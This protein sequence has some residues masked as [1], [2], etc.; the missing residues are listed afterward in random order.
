[1]LEYLENYLITG[2]IGLVVGFL[3]ARRYYQNLVKNASIGKIIEYS[4]INNNL[5]DLETEVQKLNHCIQTLK[6]IGELLGEQISTVHDIEKT[7]DDTLASNQTKPIPPTEDLT[8]LEST[9]ND[10]T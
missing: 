4:L 3:L 5:N 8:L 6:G 10:E 2:V 7:Y 9:S 1:M